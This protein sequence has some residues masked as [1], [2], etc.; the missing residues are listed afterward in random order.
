MRWSLVL[1]LALSSCGPTP[2]TSE[3]AIHE[4]G[5]IDM[6]RMGYVDWVAACAW[7]HGREGQSRQSALR[8]CQADLGIKKD[9]R[10]IP[11]Q[12]PERICHD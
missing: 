2:G 11:H 12:R 7:Q 10:A 8:N 4:R 3:R 5:A 9:C 1:I 6:I